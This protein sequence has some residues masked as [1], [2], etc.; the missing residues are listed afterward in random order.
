MA[1]LTP[2]QYPSNAMV[3]FEPLNAALGD[4]GKGMDAEYKGQAGRDFGNAMANG[5]TA[6]AQIAGA[7]ID[8]RLAMDAGLYSGKLE[9]QSQKLEKGMRELLGSHAQTLSEM[10]DP[11]Q[12]AAALN[13]W[14]DSSPRVAAGLTKLGVD[15]KVNPDLAIKSI[16]QDALGAQDPEHQKLVQ[17]QTGKANRETI[18]PGN[19]VVDFS[20][21]QTQGRTVVQ[22]D[23]SMK[24]P[25]ERAQVARNMGL[26]EDSPDFKAIVVNGK[27]PDVVPDHKE[28]R[29]AD[30]K[31]INTKHLV[32]DLE[33]ALQTSK[34]F[35][36]GLS[37][38]AAPV[39]NA[40][41]GTENSRAVKDF[42]N[43]VQNSVLPNLKS[44][45]G[46]RVTNVDVLLMK[47]LAGAASMPQ[48]NREKVLN[49]A[50]ARAKEIQ[51]EQERNA[52][53]LRN[54]DYYK[55]G[56]GPQAP[57]TVVNGAAGGPQVTKPNTGRLPPNGGA[58]TADNPIP[59][60][61]TPEQAVQ[62]YG[63]KGGVV[64]QLPDGRTKVIP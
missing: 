6:G 57:G 30:D 52:E 20:P 35:T 63:G 62:Q 4:Y 5:D 8:P 23:L 40:F 42:D 43:L 54:R 28:I 49:R 10:P 27:L 34:T 59:F 61:G 18:E 47:D 21:G 19:R 58:G 39:L 64:I 31:I 51:A 32:N 41:G 33:T 7:K 53:Q 24:T 25:G 46:A 45:F 55:A 12:R 48:E 13:K 37:A 16:Y 29:A 38:T 26:A 17:A 11:A 2:F 44:T 3:N 9:E 1:Q 50:I 15:W 14:V 60:A 36:G 56:G 22:G